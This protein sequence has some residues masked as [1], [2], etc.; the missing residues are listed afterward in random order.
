MAS[1]DRSAG[2]SHLTSG[3]NRSK[4]QARSRARKRPGAKWRAGKEFR[5]VGQCEEGED[6]PLKPEMCCREREGCGGE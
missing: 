3:P 5:D 6:V 1:N 4:C 2:R